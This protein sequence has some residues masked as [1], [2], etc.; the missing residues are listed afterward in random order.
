MMPRW[1]IQFTCP[2]STGLR[3]K[4]STFQQIMPCASPV[5]MRRSISL[6]IGRP[7]IFAERFSINSSDMERFSC[8]ASVRSSASWLSMER[9]CLSS[10][11]VLLRA[12][13][14]Y[15]V[16]AYELS[17]GFR[18]SGDCDIIY[19]GVDNIFQL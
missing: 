1:S 16:I 5:C 4:R 6:K 8:L 10:T 2:S 12:Y 7:G 3:A 14:K 13:K 11:S 19:A 17:T 18:R 15:L 9:T